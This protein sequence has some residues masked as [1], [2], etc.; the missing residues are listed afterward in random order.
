MKKEGKRGVFSEEE[1][2][3]AH[4]YSK[5][6]FSEDFSAPSQLVPGATEDCSILNQER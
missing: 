3:Q 4:N 6:F 1:R 2:N 5:S